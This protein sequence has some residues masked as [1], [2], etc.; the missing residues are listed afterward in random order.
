M[1]S[2]E[3]KVIEEDF[4]MLTLKTDEVEKSYRPKE[5]EDSRT[6]VKPKEKRGNPP[7]GN[8]CT[9]CGELNRVDAV[10]CKSCWQYLPGYEER[11][12]VAE[13]KIRRGMQRLATD[14]ADADEAADNRLT[15][16]VP[17]RSAA[18]MAGNPMRRSASSG[19]GSTIGRGSAARG[20]G[21][22]FG[23]S[24]AKRMG[25]SMSASI[26]DG[27][28]AGEGSTAKREMPQQESKEGK[29]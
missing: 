19:I 7:P 15:R 8:L 24:T 22:P 11:V 27:W 9:R 26:A 4:R 10:F 12:E 3:Q 25:S 5:V 1:L 21:I 18:R 17:A 2:S 14:N 13:D 28:R 29:C 16:F 6:Q 20:G 23:G